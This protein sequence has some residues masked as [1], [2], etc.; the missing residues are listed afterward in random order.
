MNTAL[1]PILREG[2]PLIVLTSAA[3][4]S[5]LTAILPR[6]RRLWA[7]AA[8]AVTGL[9]AAAAGYF[10]Q[11]GSKTSWAGPYLLGDPFSHFLSLLVCT[12]GIATILLSYRYWR[13][14]RE[15]L[16]EFFML[17]LFSVLG[18]T[19]LVST[20]HWLVLVLGLEVMSLALY[21]LVGLRR[22]DRESS[23]AAFKYFLLGSVA[24]AFLLFGVSLLYGATGSLELGG[25]NAVPAQS[26]LF[27]IL[28]LGGLLALLGFVFKVAAA[29]FHFW[30]PDV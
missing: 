14:Q 3:I 8:L 18:M 23:E 20:A 24:T 22:L 1:A 9:G 11:W 26:D 2:W 4:L 27:P 15:P 12:I 6:A 5:L 16:P 30:A 13:E 29:P 21:V 19:I 10:L 17:I 25:I 7:S 28:K